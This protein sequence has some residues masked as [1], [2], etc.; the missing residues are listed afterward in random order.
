M[1]LYLKQ[2]AV[3]G[4]FEYPIAQLGNCRDQKECH[5]YCE[6]PQNKAA[7]WS[8]GV[9]TI[10]NDVLGDESPEE[11]LAE[12]G[13]T[14]PIPELGNCGNATECKAYCSDPANSEACRTYSQSRRQTVKA[15]ILEKARAELG[16]T[17]VEECKAFC[18][19][20]T[21]KEVCTAFAKRHRL[22]DAAKERLI[23]NAKET[24]GCTTRE[25]CR[26]FCEAEANKDKC[27]EFAQNL[28]MKIRHKV[29]TR[30]G[31]ATQEECRQ[32]CEEQP[33]KCPDFPKQPRINTS[34]NPQ[35][36]MNRGPG[37]FDKKPAFFGNRLRPS[38]RPKNQD[39]IENE[40]EIEDE[41]EAE[42]AMASPH[43]S[44]SPS[45]SAEEGAG[46]L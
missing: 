40:V 45:Q 1:T 41:V 25:E 5:L 29:Q 16:C 15:R 9:Y 23:E 32:I 6:V 36:L 28:G 31:C 37:S 22:K 27:R 21:N 7:C 17:S 44:N 38:I 26:T 13:I 10:K 33:E 19:E 11:K 4:A 14:F 42:D 2:S 8:Y 18:A 30:L 43:T 12:V 39:E 46:S 20:E 24:L 34:P 3:A 35:K